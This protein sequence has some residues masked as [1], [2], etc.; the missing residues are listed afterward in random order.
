MQ[1]ATAPRVGLVSDSDLHRHIL[2]TVLAEQGCQL[3]QSLNSQSLNHYFE[4]KSDAELDVWLVD[5]AGAGDQCMLEVLMDNS[6]LQVLV[7]DDIPP[8]QEQSAH[9]IWQ[10]QLIAKLEVVVLRREAEQSDLSKSTTDRPV[11]VDNIWVLGASLGGPEAVKRFVNALPAGLQVAMVY[12][13]HIETNFDKVLTN[14]MGTK[15]AYPMQVVDNNACLE[16]GRIV[17]VPPDKQLRFLPHGQIV[18]TRKP[19]IGVYQPAIDQVIADLARIYRQRL[20]VIIFSGLC[21]DGEIGCRVAKAC[22]ATVWVQCPSSCRS[23]D[24][25]EAALSTGCV[26]FQGTP[27]QLAHALTER[28]NTVRQQRW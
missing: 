20:G 17:V 9:E 19:W 8:V 22:G 27:E 24:M 23:A 16:P 15:H 10:R 12:A 21:N 2:R 28:L 13:Q 26:S 5:L 4:N 18:A 1:A 14:A 7:I 3:T 6:D 25:V 11:A